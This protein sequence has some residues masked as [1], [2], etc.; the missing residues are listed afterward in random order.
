MKI[1]QTPS[2]FHKGEILAQKR[3]GANDIAQWAGDFIRDYLPEQ[4]RDFY[5]HLPFLIVCGSDNQRNVWI[6]LIE[7]DEDFIQ[8]PNK[9]LITLSAKINDDDP[10]KLS[11][12]DGSHI[13]VL[14][15][16]LQNRRRNRFSGF[17]KALNTGYEIKIGQTFGNC[18]QYI[19]PRN[20]TRE[21]TEKPLPAISSHELSNEQQR[22]ITHADTVFIGSGQLN[23]SEPLSS[24]FDASH[25]GG[26]PG[27]VKVMTKTRLYLPDYSG[28]NFFNTIGN[29]ISDGRIALVFIDFETGGLLHISGHAKIDWEPVNPH[30]SAAKRM[31]IIDIVN[32]IERPN[33]LSLR[34]QKQ[35][36]QLLNLKLIKREEESANITSFYFS[37]VDNT[38]LAPYAGGQH[39]PIEIQIPGQMGLSKRSYSLSSGYDDGQYYRISVKREEMGVVSRF[40]HDQFN[41]GETLKAGR[42]TGSFV[43]DNVDTP[44]VLISAGVGFTPLL[45]MLQSLVEQTEKPVWYVHGTQNSHT[46]ALHHEV[47][48]ITEQYNHF[49]HVTFYSK[50]LGNDKL[51][52]DYNETG[53]INAH[54]LINL[55]KASNTQYFLCG[56]Y[57]FMAEIRQNLE[58]LGVLETHIHYESF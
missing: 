27:F 5:T 43:I 48:N 46:H 34:W 9:H 17:I 56:T 24:G 42:P 32:V 50:P 45:S 29:I 3:A 11:F 35:D 28:N 31:I 40:L 8:S 7:G 58:S 30:D 20:W 15:I 36:D 12:S 39:L 22:F 49:N 33:A 57:G 18:P 54:Y 44:I 55:C 1:S 21:F 13:G 14:G 38:P 19:H 37:T 52:K 10:L 4:H 26:E 23:E 41:T 25:R 2:P 47:K 51:G 16:E 6:T 53:R